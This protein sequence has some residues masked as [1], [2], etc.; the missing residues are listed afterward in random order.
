MTLLW[1]HKGLKLGAE[2][3][4][5]EK[6]AEQGVRQSGTVK[7]ASKAWPESL[8]IINITRKNGDVGLGMDLA[9]TEFCYSLR[10]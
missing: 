1:R 3:G 5:A 8:E 6:R 10:F 9:L 4:G 7:R 2:S